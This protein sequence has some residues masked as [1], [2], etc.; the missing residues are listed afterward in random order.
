MDLILENALNGLMLAL[1][2]AFMDFF[3][4]LI[5]SLTG[6]GEAIGGILL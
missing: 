3:L 4:A 1:S 5:N 6:I 2:A